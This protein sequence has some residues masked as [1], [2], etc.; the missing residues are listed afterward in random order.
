MQAAQERLSPFIATSATLHVVLFVVVVFVPAL[1]PGRT[2]ETWGTSSDKG[3]KVGVTSSLPGIPLPS[4]RVVQETAKGNK[5]K[6]LNPAETAPRAREKAL[7]EP[8]AVKV[9]SGRKKPDQKKEPD[10]RVAKAA[11]QPTVSAPS[12]A[13]PGPASGQLALPYGTVAAGTGQTTFGDG[14][15]GARFPW[16]VE[17]MTRAIKLAW[18]DNIT[19][20]FGSAPKVSET[21]SSKRAAR[22][23]RRMVLPSGSR[24]CRVWAGTV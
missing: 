19:V 3:I 9:P 14:T 10:S 22:Q 13:V 11:P 2:H 24:P 16:Y 15:F 7:S 23:S 21:V 5:S 4:P 20:P 1:F 8:A 12:N 17:N 6:S 18:Q